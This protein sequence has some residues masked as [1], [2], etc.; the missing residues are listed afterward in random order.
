MSRI[1]PRTI[2]TGVTV[3]H[4]SS[5][6]GNLTLRL[7][8]DERAALDVAAARAGFGPRQ[9]SVYLRRLLFRTAGIPV[10]AAAKPIGRPHV[11]QDDS[12]Q[13]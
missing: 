4:G 1:K 10:S 5:R 2:P 6:T 13:A 11:V 9:L 7:T 8:P 3:P 12:E